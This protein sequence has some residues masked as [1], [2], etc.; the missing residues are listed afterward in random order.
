MS[1]SFSQ[2]L[3]S[4]VSQGDQYQPLTQP[5]A[6]KSR[7][8][9]TRPWLPSSSKIAAYNYFDQHRAKYSRLESIN[10]SK[11]TMGNM[12]KEVQARINQLPSTFSKMLEEAIVF[13][14]EEVSKD[15]SKTLTNL[16]SVEDILNALIAVFQVQG[17]ETQ[18]N[19]KNCLETT[20]LLRMVLRAVKENQE[21]TA[22]EMDNLKERID[23]QTKQSQR[24]LEKLNKIVDEASSNSEDVSMGKVDDKLPMF[25]VGAM[26]QSSVRD[27]KNT[28]KESCPNGREANSPPGAPPTAARTAVRKFSIMRGLSRQADPFSDF[29]NIMK[30]DDL[31]SDSDS[32]S[33]TE[34]GWE[35]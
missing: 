6:G 14:E 11:A 8:D 25:K 4:Q 30:V 1:F 17:E 23:I 31:D 28:G 12:L 16:S 9:M 20:A 13:L 29:S 22:K 3:S 7:Q 35:E 34:C 33:D 10:P 2:S 21:D 5:M 18:I 19:S 27:V 24:L 26:E 15:K 32:D